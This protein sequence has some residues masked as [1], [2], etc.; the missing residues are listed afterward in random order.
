MA[1]AAAKSAAKAVAGKPKPFFGDAKE[2]VPVPVETVK[3]K[4]TATNVS[5]DRQAVTVT[6]DSLVVT[7]PATAKSKELGTVKSAAYR[8]PFNLS[9][10][11]T[12]LGVKVDIRGNVAKSEGGRALV[13]SDIA[14]Q[15]ASMEFEFG[16]EVNDN[17]ELSYIA[18]VD[19]LSLQQVASRPPLPEIR[20]FIT[21]VSQCLD[22]KDQVRLTVDSLDLSLV[23]PNV[24]APE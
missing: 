9:D 19:R 23:G 3:P 2:F 14:G 7:T 10:K 1:K 17:Y 22:A 16:D 5:E 20:V 24:K 13:I 18:E 21:L 15:T 11:T 12:L 8:I 4:S 6:F